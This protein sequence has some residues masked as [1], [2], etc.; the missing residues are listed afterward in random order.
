MAS[1][2]VDGMNDRLRTA[3]LRAGVG[4]ADLAEAIGVDTKT[5]T[6]WL[7]GRVPHH[8]NRL[9]VAE[10]LGETEATLW[11][12]ARPDQSPGSATTAEVVGAWAHRA[13][14]P[15]DLWLALLNGS[16]DRID[17]MG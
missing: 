12:T 8:R 16:R 10:R 1:R 5:V 3:M 2:T 15:T 9:L 11:P 4:A 14:V 7:R 13:E 6:R 17:L